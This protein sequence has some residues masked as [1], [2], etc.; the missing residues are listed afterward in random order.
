MPGDSGRHKGVLCGICA[1]VC[2]GTNPFGALPLYEEGVNTSS[3]LFYRFCVGAILLGLLM[4]VRRR[5][6]SV[7]WCEAKVLLA[8]G[9]LFSL[10]S[11]TYYQSFR[12]MEAGIA[13]TILFVYPV[14]VAVIMGVFYGERVGVGTVL[15]ILLSLVGGSSG[16]ALSGGGMS[17]VVVSAVAYAVYIVVVN[18]SGVRLSSDVLTFYVLLT[19]VCS[20]F[21]YSRVAPGQHLMLP[22]SARSWFY[23]LWLGLV[24]TVLSLVLMAVSVHVVG[25]T[26]TAIM[27]A[28]EPLTAV[29]IG[30]TVFGEELA[31]RQVVGLLSIVLAVMVVVLSKKAKG[32]E[33][34]ETFV[35]CVRDVFHIGRK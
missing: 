19:C 24:P 23:A 35:S 29:V 21:L 31:V 11:I 32:R 33:G 27:G 7:A 6:L 10:S 5:R 4:V 15:S 17:L 34:I 12:F 20:L 18:R 25:A 3:V 9:L 16:A 1:A 22:P 13:S 14:M 28:L 30:V 26:P 2:Y 8:L